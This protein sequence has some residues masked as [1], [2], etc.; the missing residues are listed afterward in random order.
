MVV[1]HRSDYPDPIGFRTGET[2]SVGREDTEYPG[3]IRV[4]TADGNEGWAPREF[5][6]RI[7]EGRATARC[8]YDA[9]ELDTTEGESLVVHGETAGW[10]LAETADGRRGWVPQQSVTDE[11]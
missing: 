4:C 5:L 2:V 1:A 9:R 10:F 6:D 8:D 7:S 11:G 3:W